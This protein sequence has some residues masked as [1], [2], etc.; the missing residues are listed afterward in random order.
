LIVKASRQSI[1]L[2]VIYALCLLGATYNHAKIAAKYGLFWNYGAD[3]SEVTTLFWTSLTIIDPITVILLFWRPNCGVIATAVL[4][5]IDVGTNVWIEFRYFPPLLHALSQDI[6]VDEQIAFM[7]FVFV[8]AAFAWDRS[9]SFTSR[10][11]IR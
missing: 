9:H 4:M 5:I 3:F 2:R 11:K 8:T 1:I 7:L 10:Y 6:Q